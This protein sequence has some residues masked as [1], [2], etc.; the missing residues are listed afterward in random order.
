MIFFKKKHNEEQQGEMQRESL[1]SEEIEVLDN[2]IKKNLKDFFKQNKKLMSDEEELCYLLPN[3]IKDIID[4]FSDLERQIK[5]CETVASDSYINLLSDIV[6][7]TI[8]T[9]IKELSRQRMTEKIKERA[10]ADAKDYYQTPRY[11]RPWRRFFRL[12]P[13]RAMQLILEQEELEARKL[14]LQQQI[15]NDNT[16]RQAEQQ[17]ELYASGLSEE[18]N[19]NPIEEVAT[20]P[21][22]RVRSAKP[23]E[24]N[25][26]EQGE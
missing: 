5:T 25:E 7:I 20:L 14:H 21:I 2:L 10:S 6:E 13:N 19:D 11:Y 22:R 4:E 12:T 1:S 26:E 17:E 23:D 15:N 24:V 9:R 18:D 3:D 16:R 8:R